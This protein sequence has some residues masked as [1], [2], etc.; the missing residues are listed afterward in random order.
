MIKH[1]ERCLNVVSM[2]AYSSFTP[3]HKTV[4]SKFIE[5]TRIKNVLLYGSRSQ[6]EQST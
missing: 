5:Q 4:V 2:C 1:L 6:V 3:C